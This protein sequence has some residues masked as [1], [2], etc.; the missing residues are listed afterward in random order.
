[1]LSSQKYITESKNKKRHNPNYYKDGVVPICLSIGLW[2]NHTQT[3]EPISMKFA[4][5]GLYVPGIDIGLFPSRF[6]FQ[7][8]GS[9]IDV[10]TYRILYS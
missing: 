8:G 9:L 2:F 10:T 1:M 5:N 4:Q 3:T 7:D 6:S